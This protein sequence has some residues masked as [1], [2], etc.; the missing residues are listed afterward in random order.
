MM[1]EDRRPETRK[2]IVKRKPESEMEREIKMEMET[3]KGREKEMMNRK[4]NFT[5]IELL[6]VIAIIAILA[7]MLL[8]ALNAAREKGKATSCLSNEKQLGV[9]MMMYKDDNQGIF[10]PAYYYLNSVD[11]SNGYM[12]WSGMLH[13]YA[14]A[15]KAYVCPS[16]ANGGWAPYCVSATSTNAFG[17]ACTNP[18][19]Q[20]NVVKGNGDFQVPRICYTANELIM[21][22]LK[23]ASYVDRLKLVKD[24]ELVGPSREILVAEFT[25]SDKRLMGSSAQSGAGIKSHRPTDGVADDAGGT[26][27]NADDS[28]PGPSVLFAVTAAQAAAAALNPT[29]SSIHL[30]YTQWD[31]HSDRGNYLFADGHSDAK[32]VAETLDPNRFLWGLRGYSIR[33]AAGQPRVTTDG[34]TSVQ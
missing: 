31:R 6:V 34:T 8:P 23:C 28:A 3:K 16:V 19:G 14:K 25:D 30:N 29:A 27:Y 12:H 9:A 4:S 7:G 33:S 26:A 2:M 20:A 17:E 24:T 1:M 22:R 18:D 15:N 10:P 13:N 5:L 32:T 11:D 21:P